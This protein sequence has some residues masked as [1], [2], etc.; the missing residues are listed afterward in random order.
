MQLGKK[1]KEKTSKLENK[2]K[3]YLCSQMTWFYFLIIFGE[4][5]FY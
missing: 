3:D 4:F 2:K 5:Q 1:K